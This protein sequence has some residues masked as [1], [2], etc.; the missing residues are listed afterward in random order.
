MVDLR[1]HVPFL[2]AVARGGTRRR[3]PP[4]TTIEES[5][6]RSGRRA[7]LLPGPVRDEGVVHGRVRIVR[8]GTGGLPGRN[9]MPISTGDDGGHAVHS[10]GDLCHKADERPRYRDQRH[11]PNIEQAAYEVQSACCARSSSTGAAPGARGGHHRSEGVRRIRDRRG[12]VRP[13]SVRRANSA[14]RAAQRFLAAIDSAE[15]D[16]GLR[17]R[18]M[19][20]ATAEHLHTLAWE[21]LRAPDGRS[22]RSPTQRSTSRASCR[23]TAESRSSP[24]A[25]A[26]CPRWS[27]SR[28]QRTRTFPTCPRSTS[29]ASARGP[30]RR[31]KRFRRWCS[32]D[33]RPISGR[34]STR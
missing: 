22:G 2:P 16:G 24:H 11:S 34:R 28:R 20:D 9:L 3:C 13:R 23:L 33:R 15:R 31:S 10:V 12:G 26:H 29:R 30:P 17:V 27:R 4:A 6:S 14:G 8:I 18:L 19:I 32:T 21:R 25:W 5:L 1:R 7:V